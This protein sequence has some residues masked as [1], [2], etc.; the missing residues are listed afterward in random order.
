M[1]RVYQCDF[2]ATD[3]AD[4]FETIEL[5]NDDDGQAYDASALEFRLEVTD[6]G[7]AVLTAGTEAGYTVLMTRPASNEVSWRFPRASMAGL[8][9][10]KTYKVGCV[11]EDV[12]GNITQLF[13]GELAVVDGGMA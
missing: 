13:V 1:G 2:S 7:T 3:D 8:D 5:T 9:T 4:W 11:Y 10:K 6:C 12:S